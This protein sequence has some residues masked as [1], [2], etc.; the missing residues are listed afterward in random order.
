M[1]VRNFCSSLDCTKACLVPRIIKHIEEEGYLPALLSPCTYTPG[2]PYWIWVNRYQGDL[3]TV[4]DLNTPEYPHL[5]TKWKVSVCFW[6]YLMR[7]V[8]LTIFRNPLSIFQSTLSLKLRDGWM[9]EAI[10]PIWHLFNGRGATRRRFS[11]MERSF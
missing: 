6:L 8:R 11:F 7:S 9:L 5:T 2:V 1:S 3:V 4:I 10:S